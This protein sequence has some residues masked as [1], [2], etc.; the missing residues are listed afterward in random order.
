MALAFLLSLGVA[1]MNAQCSGGTMVGTITPTG[2]YQTLSAV[3]GDYW[4]FAATAGMSYEFTFCAGGGDNLGEDTQITILDNTGADAGGY[5][6]DFCGVGSSV[7]WVP[8]TS[9]TYRVLLSEYFCT[10]SAISMGTMAYMVSLPF[11]PCASIANI[12]ACG[13][14]TTTA[15][16]SGAG[17]YALG[18]YAPPGKETIFTF[19]P[20]A[21]GPYTITQNTNSVGTWIDYFFKPVS[22]GCNNT[23]WTFI[24]DINASPA[25]SAAFTM[26]AGVQYYIMLDPEGTAGGSVNWTLNCICNAPTTPVLSATSSTICTGASTTLSISS[27]TLNDATTW[28]W[29]SGSCNGTAAGTGTSIT[30]SPTATTTYFARGT[31]GCVTT[32]SCGQ[33][34]ITTTTPTVGFTASPGTTICSGSNVTLSGTGAVSY[35]WSAG[36]TNGVAFTPA[37]STTYT[38]TGTDGGGC[39]ATATASISLAALPTGTASASPATL[40]L[41]APTTLTSVATPQC[42]PVSGFTGPFAPANW[43]T[44]LTNSNGTVTTTSAPASISMTS[45]N[46]LSG[47]GTTD[48]SI[49]VTCA[50]TVT[51]NWGYTTVDGANYDQPRYAVN[52]GAAVNMTGFNTAGG[53]TQN[54]TQS[55]TVAAGDV[56]H[57]QAYSTDN[58]FGACTVTISN[59][60]A[61]ANTTP[62]TAWYTVASSGSSFATGSSVSATPS[63]AG[64]MNYYA[65]FTN[66]LGCVS[67]PRA[68]APVT[69]NALPS[70]TAASSVSTVCAG[71]MVTLNGGGA[72]SYTWDNGATDNV[73]FPAT[74]TTMYTVTGTDANGCTNTA[75]TTV[76]VNPLPVVT[77][78][79]TDNDVCIGDMITLNGGGAVSYTWDNGATDNVA[80]AAMDTTMYTVTGTDANGCVNTASTTVDVNPLPVVT[81]TATDNEVCAGDMV[82]LNGG[83]A[84]SYAWDNGAT[85]NVAFA[86]MDTTMYTVT[87]T[88]VNGCVNTA[89]TTVIVNPLPMVTATSSNDTVCAGDS[90]MVMG[91]GATSYTWDNG[92]TDN[93]NFAAMSTTLYTV[94]GTD[95]NGCMNTDTVTV[96]VNAL[97]MVTATSSND[98]VCAGDSVM[99]MGGGATSYTWDNGVTDNMNFAAMSTTL[100]TVTG[101]DGNGCMNTDTVTVHVNA[102]PMVTAA[103][104]DDTI[105]AGDTIVVMGGGAMSYTWDNGAMDNVSF[106]PAATTLYTV[107][108]TDMNGCMNTASTNVTV[109]AL[110]AV[111]ASASDNTA[112]AGEMITVNGGGAATYSWNNGVTDNVAFTAFSGT[113]VVT[114]TDANG[115]VNSDSTIVVVNSLPIVTFSPLPVDT[116]CLN[117]LPMILTGGSPLGGVYSGAGVTAGSFDPFAAGVGLIPV[118]YTYTDVNSCSASASQNVQVLTCVGVEENVFASDVNIYPNPANGAFN[119]SISNASF[120]EM[121]ISII[122]IQGKEVFNM[123]ENNIT[124]QYNKQINIDQLAKGMYYI[125]LNTKSDVKIL[126]LSVN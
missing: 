38:V 91:G 23:G 35:A 62:T 90:V 75:S 31:G 68:A 53:T 83:G 58:A 12:A 15:I 120:T 27:G 104:S 77:A 17:S 29:Y 49:T 60:V 48:Y 32:S 7:T 63:A 110:P 124:S 92:V 33:I 106:A 25:T 98:T 46:G 30:V 22:G 28:T 76:T 109:N 3:A 34:T 95:V 100:Y 5:N 43:T 2:T 59:F 39:T 8:A 103:A 18:P 123:V 126:K 26:T 19:T 37:S 40:C 114:G 69:V 10:N 65:E 1:K 125:R 54:G 36:V 21:T 122:D 86:A 71:D 50:G 6:D 82:T 56:I 108:G 107:T 87:G 61:P 4:E 78:T 97:P 113:F 115:C 112:C 116:L 64:A 73:A 66:V 94:T 47:A 11:D 70:V 72:V 20:S 52:S 55:I 105:C 13:T 67:S 14:T 121:V 24:Q 111:T 118:T 85:D 102:L 41:G 93:V 80:F 117:S 57:L 42:L 101:T 16:P 84:M 79:A 74:A 9:G 81:A 45:S 89:S 96:H 99:V 44:T 51:F 119:I 88:D